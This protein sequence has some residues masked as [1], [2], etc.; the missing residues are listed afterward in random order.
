LRNKL[1]KTLVT[2]SPVDYAR[3]VF[4]DKYEINS[5]DM[6]N[7]DTVAIVYTPK[8]GFAKEGLYVVLSGK[9]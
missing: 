7:E 9:Y 3:I 1:S 6:V 4:S 2:Q 8:D 5:V